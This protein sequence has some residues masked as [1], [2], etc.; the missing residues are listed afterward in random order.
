MDKSISHTRKIYKL[1]G[2][3][4]FE[5]IE[6]YEGCDI[7]NCKVTDPMIEQPVNFERFEGRKNDKK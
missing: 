6:Q 7:E 5:K 3:V 4:I 1:F 2:K